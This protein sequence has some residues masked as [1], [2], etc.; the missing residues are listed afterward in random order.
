MNDRIINLTNTG[1]RPHTGSVFRVFLAL[2][3][4][5]TL[6]S[7]Y[8]ATDKLAVFA[9]SVLSP[10]QVDALSG[11]YHIIELDGD[12]RSLSFTPRSEPWSY[13]QESPR[14]GLVPFYM[15]HPQ[16]L[17]TANMSFKTFLRS[18]NGNV[19]TSHIDG[20][21][22]FS[23]IPG[24]D[25][26]LGSIPEE[27][28]QARDELG[29]MSPPAGEKNKASNTFFILRQDGKAMT[30]KLF[31]KSDEGLKRA[32]PDIKLSSNSPLPTDRVLAYLEKH[33]AKAIDKEGASIYLRSTQQQKERVEQKFEMAVSEN[34]K[35]EKAKIARKKAKEDATRLKDEAKALEIARL[36]AAKV[37][38]TSSGNSN[39]TRQQMRPLPSRRTDC[40]DG[41]VTLCNK[42]DKTA[43]IATL[44]REGGFMCPLSGNGCNVEVEGWWRLKPG[45][46]YQP[47]MGLFWETYY[48]VVHISNGTRT[49]PTWSRDERL[50]SGDKYRGLSGHSGYSI[51]VKKYDNFHRK[52]SGK[53]IS[54][55]NETC[56]VGYEKSK[57][58]LYTRGS[59]DYDLTYSIK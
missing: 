33:A 35:K 42:S 12:F 48:S 11:H 17:A 29:N 45:Q 13:K 9:R 54:A 21:V 8:M 30:V 46:C 36:K 40:S 26:I 4:L 2:L 41:C 47:N 27:T 31:S 38:Q 10:Q 50:L 1:L 43:H 37:K 58:N 22:V 57:V 18:D 15:K 7:C 6:T 53:P 59:V 5:L 25:L 55:F 24:T 19:F 52:I 16:Q 49:Y 56:P 14:V 32:F 44:H 23:H 28:L 51:C 34:I 3:F 20:V 39:Q